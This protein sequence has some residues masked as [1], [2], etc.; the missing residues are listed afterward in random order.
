MRLVPLV[1][2]LPRVDELDEIRWRAVAERDDDLVGV[3]VYGVRTTSVYC[4]PGC[5]ARRPLRDNVE[6]FA[7]PAEATA[8]GYRACRRCSPDRT[9]SSNPAV[10]AVIA[11]CRQL[12][13]GDDASVADMATALGY[14]ERHLRRR[15][16]DVTGVSIGAYRRA[17]RAV[18]IRGALRKG[19]SVT[20]A[21]FD[22]GYGSFRGF[23]EFGA[24]QLG[25]TPGRYRDGARGER[26]RYTSVATPLGFVVAGCTSRGVCAIRL[27][28]DENA[29]T[30]DLHE[31]FP[32]ATIERDDGG[33]ADVATVL[34]GA[35]RG[36]GDPTVLPLDVA[37]TA[38]QIRVWEALR[39]IPAGQTRTYSQVA[40]EIGA[41]TAVRAVASACAA[42]HVALAVPCHRVVRRDGSLGG[43]RWGVEVKE[44]L[45]RAEGARCLL[46]LD[47]SSPTS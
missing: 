35:M 6:Y 15:F 31:E 17:Q 13:Q 16:R 43:Y 30:K 18:R 20:D 39:R 45:L 1:P 4:R 34:V 8:A 19:S 23:Y 40:S 44:S 32:N 37:G 47:A 3:F 42:N 33:L 12:E 27:G 14:S 38:F 11:V 26:I 2:R 46:G 28:G 7:T 5:G 21:V 29:L 24:A 36:E 25:M 41:P 10:M 22:A 9:R